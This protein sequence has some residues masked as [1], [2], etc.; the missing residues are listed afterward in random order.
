[1]CA[2]SG[3]RKGET[4]Q[5]GSPEADM[6]PTRSRLRT[7]AVSRVVPHGAFG[8]VLGWGSNDLPSKVITPGH[9]QG[10][11]HQPRHML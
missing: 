9:P 4:P 1:V 2:L 7:S 3:R 10:G 5:Q 11:H 6:R 8:P